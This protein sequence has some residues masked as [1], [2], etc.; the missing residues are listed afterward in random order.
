MVK[1]SE[2][3]RNTIKSNILMHLYQHFPKELFTNEIS[4][5]EARDE[6]FIKS[7]LHELKE[8]NLVVSIKKNEKGN[9]F[10]R[11][12][13]WQLT[14]QAYQAYYQRASQ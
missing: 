9:L 12:I 6:E 5:L 8:K 10:I 7:L 11:R 2:E 1:I 13:R 4:K 14:P 3:K